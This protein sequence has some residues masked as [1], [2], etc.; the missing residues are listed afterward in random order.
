MFQFHVSISFFFQAS[1]RDVSNYEQ[2]AARMYGTG[3]D[4]GGGGGGRRNGD[5]SQIKDIREKLLNAAN[6]KV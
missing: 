1:L 3:G 2:E 5:F 4:R 6:E